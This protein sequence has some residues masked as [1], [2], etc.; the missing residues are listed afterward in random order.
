MTDLLPCPF[1][2]G[3]VK[4]ILPLKEL[5]FVLFR[6]VCIEC[7]VTNTGY[8]IEEIVDKWNKRIDNEKNIQERIKN[9]IEKCKPI[10]E[11]L[12]KR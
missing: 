5:N 7:D 11:K 8:S 9:S 6:I 10:L 3:E 1:C 4:L 2:G 12:V